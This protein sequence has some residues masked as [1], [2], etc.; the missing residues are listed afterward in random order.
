MKTHYPSCCPTLVEAL[1]HCAGGRPCTHVKAM[2]WCYDAA[3]RWG[4]PDDAEVF[5]RAAARIAAEHDYG[6]G[7]ER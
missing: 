7:T 1:A 6:Q 5:R 3:I 2:L 4:E